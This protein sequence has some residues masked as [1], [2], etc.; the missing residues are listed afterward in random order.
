MVEKR[1]PRFLLN[2]AC[3]ISMFH[4]MYVY[5]LNIVFDFIIQS[6]MKSKI[7]T[8]RIDIIEYAEVV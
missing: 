6:K 8:V 1:V 3:D 2:D 4:I 5:V 7:T